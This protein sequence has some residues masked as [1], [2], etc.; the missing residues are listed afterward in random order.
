[1]AFFTEDQANAL[2]KLHHSEE[3]F[4]TYLSFLSGPLNDFI[5]REVAPLAAK[6][7]AE[8]MFSEENFHALGELGFMALPVAEEFGGAEACFSYFNAGLESLSKADA[9]F[10]LGVAI[11]GTMTEGIAKFGSEE[12][13]NR[14]VPDLASGKLIGAFALS[15]A[16]SGSD[17][18]S[19]KTTWTLF[20]LIRQQ[21]SGLCIYTII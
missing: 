9:G 17:A 15:E 12:L 8:E 1:M 20:P 13:R 2:F 16:G 18:Q 14:Y 10:A 4:E 11:H 19:L 5:T 6:N 21:I 7:D 3:D